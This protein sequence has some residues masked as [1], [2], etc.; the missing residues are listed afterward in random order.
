MSTVELINVS[1]VYESARQGAGVYA[2]RDFSLTI[3]EG[4]LVTLVGPSGCGK[5]TTLRMVAGLESITSGEIRVGGRDISRTPV[6][7]RGLGM[8][9]QSYALFPHMTV[10]Q[11]VGYGLEVQSLSKSEIAER[12]SQVLDLMQ[13]T[14]LP[15]RLPGQLSGGQ[16]QRVALASAVVTEP[17]VLLFDEPLS[18]LDAKLREYM[19]A[20]L[21]AIQQRVGI[22][23]I[24]VTHDQ[25]EA[26]T[27][28]DRVVIMNEGEL[29]QAGSPREVYGRPVSRFVADFMGKA[30][31]L[32]ATVSQV[33][34]EEATVTL[35]GVRAAAVVADGFNPASG[36]E[37]L[38]VVRPESLLIGGDTGIPGTVLSAVFLGASVEYRV[39]IAGKPVSIS[40]HQYLEHG[41]FEVGSAVWLQ[42]RP[43][44][45]SIVP[46]DGAAEDAEEEAA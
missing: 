26:M 24:Y 5:T 40:D 30:A 4:E 12:V 17:A 11:N 14:K 9:F 38:C 2:V 10:A 35:A 29:Q 45:F 37:V 34:G 31:F 23:S 8:V 46:V 6:H 41:W 22:T 3:A 27:L 16:Q 13:L 42:P 36:T 19:R 39:E 21:R 44:G 33:S 7:R 15:D 1:K 28:S 20:E 32:P 43:G 18:N 25:T